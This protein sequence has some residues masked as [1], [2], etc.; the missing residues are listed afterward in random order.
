MTTTS[1]TQSTSPVKQG[2]AAGTTFAAAILLLAAGLVSVLQGI[3]ALADN[4]LFVVGINYTYQFDITTW[5]WI[6]V[7]LGA[8]GIVVALGL[9]AGASWARG[10]AFVIAALSIVANFL[11]MPYY[12]LWSILIIALDIV[13]IWAV[14]TWRPSE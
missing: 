3:A 2:I 7:I 1:Q 4:N 6:H 11:W 8:V 5:G 12:P 9:F 10:L 14:A 13:V